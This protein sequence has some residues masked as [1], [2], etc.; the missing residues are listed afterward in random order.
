M[1]P[2]APPANASSEATRVNLRQVACEMKNLGEM[3]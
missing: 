1:G 2:D 3:R